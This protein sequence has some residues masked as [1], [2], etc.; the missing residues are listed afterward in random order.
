MFSDCSSLQSVGD[1]SG[2]DVNSI[3]DFGRMFYNCPSL[4]SVGDL[5]GWDVSSA[6]N[7]S[8]MFYNCSSLQSVGDLSGWDVSSATNIS[9]MFSDCSSLQTLDLSGWNTNNVTKLDY[10]FMNA[11]IKNL[12]ISNW[13]NVSSVNSNYNISLYSDIPTY[14]GGRT[15]D[16]VISNNIT[17]FNGLKIGATG[18]MSTSADRASLRALINGLADLTGS[19]SR[20]VTLGSTLKAKLTEEDIA[21]ATAK[22]WT[23]A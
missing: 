11:K 23:I 13:S 9:S 15:I 5:S 17:I 12:D 2:W 1:L 8:S 10:M 4:Q 16:D 6:T 7:I 21:I 3:T 18:I 19:T 14:V 20:T 22:N